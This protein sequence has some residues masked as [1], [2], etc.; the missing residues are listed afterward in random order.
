MPAPAWLGPAI[1]GTLN[2]GSSL[3]NSVFSK[4]R[5]ERNTRRTIRAERELAEYAYSKDLEM[6]N[7]N[8]E[9][10]TPEAQML[11]LKSAGLN[12]N[13]VYGSGKV[14]GNTSSEQP[15]YNAPSADYSKQLPIQL[16]TMI[17]QFQDVALKQA[18]ID[19]TQQE[20]IE[21][22]I[23]N[24]VN[25]KWM[26]GIH[27]QKLRKASLETERMSKY[28][29]EFFG[30]QEAS[31]TAI[32]KSKEVKEASDALYAKYRAEFAKQGIMSGDNMIVRILGRMLIES[33]LNFNKAFKKP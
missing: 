31:K 3:L 13:L 22:D 21:K 20:V 2:L 16:P 18:V 25:K 5:S 10:N 23:A 11:R 33:G 9:Y 19:K 30:S 15:K 29:S 32:L 12:P 6:W 26:Y 14:V 28:Q 8:N 17:S 7:R 24:S 4:R 27:Y 1:G